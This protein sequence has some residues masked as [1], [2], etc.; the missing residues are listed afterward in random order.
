ML[1]NV[2]NFGFSADPSLHYEPLEVNFGGVVASSTCLF[3]QHVLYKSIHNIFL[4]FTVSVFHGGFFH[5]LFDNSKSSIVIQ[6][7]HCLFTKSY[8]IILRYIQ[9]TRH[10]HLLLVKSL[11]PNHEEFRTLIKSVFGWNFVEFDT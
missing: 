3:L 4:N 8:R 5:G 10:W 7:F 2:L 9:L 6:G 1:A 11:F